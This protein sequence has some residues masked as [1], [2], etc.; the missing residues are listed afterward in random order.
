MFEIVEV[1]RVRLACCNCDSPLCDGTYV[2]ECRQDDD[3]G[4]LGGVSYQCCGQ[5]RAGFV[6]CNSIRE[7]LEVIVHAQ[8]AHE[9]TLVPTDKIP[10][11]KCYRN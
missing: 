4:L 6:L 2:V 8:V 5:T 9:I 7:A 11:Y 10:G 3:V 1:A